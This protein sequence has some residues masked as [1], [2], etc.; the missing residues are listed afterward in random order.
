VASASCGKVSSRRDATTRVLITPG[1]TP[2]L[3][4]GVL[5]ED[6]ARLG[7]TTPAVKSRERT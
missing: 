5:P 7:A 1:D 6:H 3:V 2:H 4:F